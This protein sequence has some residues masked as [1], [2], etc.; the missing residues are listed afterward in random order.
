MTTKTKVWTI[1]CPQCEIEMYS[2]APHD[3]RIC[4]CSNQ[5]MV[6]GGFSGYVRYGGN[7]LEQLE[8]SLRYRF[9]KAS[10]QELYDDWNKRINKFGTITKKGAK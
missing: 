9:I 6:D 8:K 2:R 7:Q 3:Y 5:T 10:K 4:G 1:T